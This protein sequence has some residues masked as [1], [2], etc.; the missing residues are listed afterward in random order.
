MASFSTEEDILG[1][2]QAAH[3]DGLKVVDV[4]TPYAVHGL[5]TAMGMKRSRLAWVCFAAG[6]VGAILKLWFEFWTAGVDWPV[7]VGGKPW[8]SLPAYVPVTFEVMVLS[9][10]LVTVFV[11]LVISKLKPGKSPVLLAEG[12]T[13]DTFVLAIEEEDATFDPVRV[14]KLFERFN[15][16]SISERYGEEVS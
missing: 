1:V 14:R 6:M 5:D 16:R 8:N 9:A 10:G 2:T 12:I 15:V 4:Y 11:F 7:N 13:N 3:A